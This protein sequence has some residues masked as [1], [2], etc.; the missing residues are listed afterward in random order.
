VGTSPWDTVPLRVLSIVRVFINS[1]NE[2]DKARAL[3]LCEQYHLD[4]AAMRLVILDEMVAE[5]KRI[6]ARKERDD[7]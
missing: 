3:L 6:A 1:E 2:N 7:G 4:Y 5:S